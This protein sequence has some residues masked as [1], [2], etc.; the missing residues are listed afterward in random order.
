MW[1]FLL[2]KINRSVENLTAYFLAMMVILVFIQVVS[3]E[4]I[5]SSFPWTEEVARFLMIWITFLGASFAF[6]YGAHIG[7]EYFKMK[8]SNLLQ[9]SF[10]LIALLACSVF[11]YFMIK[12]GLDISN[13]AM[14]QTSAA[15]NIPMGYVYLVIPISGF[16]MFL[17]LVDITVKKLKKAE[18][19]EHK[20]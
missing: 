11:F 13:R 8:L 12:Y 15:L 16:L 2:K 19:N 17:N 3:R 6:Q 4:I 10:E 14:V 18:L 9:R 20:L 1:S 7:I 5:G